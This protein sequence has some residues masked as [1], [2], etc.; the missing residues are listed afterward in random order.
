[1]HYMH[2]PV[3]LAP[4]LVSWDAPRK[5]LSLQHNCIDLFLW[6][7]YTITVANVA[8]CSSES[9]D[10][11]ANPKGGIGGPG[12]IAS[13]G[14]RGYFCNSNFHAVY[15]DHLLAFDPFSCSIPTLQGSYDLITNSRHI[16]VHFISLLSSTIEFTTSYSL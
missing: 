8:K 6:D 11:M 2:A 16:R 9:E 12:N 10:R 3:L 4:R 14:I 5:Q 15:I 1:M 7:L 13:R